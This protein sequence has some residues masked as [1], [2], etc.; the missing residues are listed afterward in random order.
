MRA[1]ISIKLVIR[2]LPDSTIK[3]NTGVYILL[4]FVVCSLHV[5]LS[6]CILPWSTAHSLP[7]TLMI[8]S[9]IASKVELPCEV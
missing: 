8:F 6:L 3:H 2:F 7:V 9:L 5:N 1:C 4:M